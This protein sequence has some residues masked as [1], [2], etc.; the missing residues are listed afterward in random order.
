MGRYWLI[1]GVLVLAIAAVIGWLNASSQ[2]EL[3]QLP[4]L[5]EAT[6]PGC[7]APGQLWLT[8]GNASNRSVLSADGVISIARSYDEM[9]FAVGNFHFDGP[10]LPGL[11]RRFCA[12]IEEPELGAVDRKRVWWLARATAAV[13]GEARGNALNPADQGFLLGPSP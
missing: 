10:L 9:P 3:E 1:G 6:E 13:F 12:A 5:A 8:V 7:D 4:V 11:Q 2:T